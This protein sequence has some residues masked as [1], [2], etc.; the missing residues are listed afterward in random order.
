MNVG[1]RHIAI[2]APFEMQHVA[3]ASDLLLWL[4]MFT[5]LHLSSRSVAPACLGI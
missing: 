5:S 4:L 3:A 1:M 2:K